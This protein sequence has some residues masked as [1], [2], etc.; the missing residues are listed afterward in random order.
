[1]L[2]LATIVENEIKATKYILMCSVTGYDASGYVEYLA[3]D[4]NKQLTSIAIRSSE[5]FT[6][7]E[8]S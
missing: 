3:Y 4:L 8:L 6:Q 5:G 7:A 2:D 1:M